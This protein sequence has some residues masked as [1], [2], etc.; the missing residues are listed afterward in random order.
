[1]RS[2][3]KIGNVKV[4]LSKQGS[5]KGTFSVT[6]KTGKTKKSM[7]QNYNQ[8]QKQ[9]T[10]K[11]VS[12]KLYGPDSQGQG[13]TADEIERKIQNG[14]RKK[15]QDLQKLADQMGVGSSYRSGDK[16]TRNQVMK[17]DIQNKGG[18]ETIGNGIG[19][20]DG[21]AIFYAK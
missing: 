9:P 5:N 20:A 15:Q 21:S 4:T 12:A 14:Q 13:M 3:K 18:G 1:M 10:N 7:A 17:R 8:K 19:F 2:S 16:A 11:T 6:A